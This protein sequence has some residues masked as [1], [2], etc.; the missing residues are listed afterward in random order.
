MMRKTISGKYLENSF[1]EL[2]WEWGYFALIT[3]K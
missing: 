3:G 1:E 2:L